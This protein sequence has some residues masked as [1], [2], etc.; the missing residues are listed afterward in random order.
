MFTRAWSTSDAALRIV[1][2]LH[3]K[4]APTSEEWLEYIQ[5][6]SETMVVLQ[7]DGSR[8]RGLSISDGGGPS[9]KQREQVNDFMRRSTGGRGTISIVTADPIVRGIVRALSWFNPQARGFA[10][11]QL[12]AAIDYLGLT[13][14]QRSDFETVLNE[15]LLAYPLHSVRSTGFNSALR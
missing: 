7:G 1:V 6:L 9:A 15:A 12:S 14:Q 5:V 11:D 3:R 2:S 13:P 8:I 4:Q 10:P